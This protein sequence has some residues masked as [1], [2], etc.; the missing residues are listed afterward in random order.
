MRASE[1]VRGRYCCGVVVESVGWPDGERSW[2][3]MDGR[4]SERGLGSRVG[5]GGGD[6][7]AVMM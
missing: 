7:E 2:V 3:D 5:E 4:A 1:R 6:G